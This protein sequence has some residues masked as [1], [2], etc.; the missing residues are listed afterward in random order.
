MLSPDAP[1][2][3]ELDLPF[4]L[5]TATRVRPSLH[6]IERDGTTTKVEPRLMRVLCVLAAAPGA[7]VSREALL[8]TVWPDASVQDEALTQ[9][10]SRLR[11]ALGDRARD[12]RVIETIPKAGY[13]LVAPVTAGDG[14]PT[15]PTEPDAALPASAPRRALWGGVVLAGLAVAAWIGR[16]APPLPTPQPVPLTTFRGLELDPAIAPDGQRFAFTWDQGD[17]ATSGLFI[18]QVGSEAPV[19]LTAPEARDRQPAWSLDGRTI[20]FARHRDGERQL[21]VVPSIGGRATPVLRCATDRN[22]PLAWTPDGG[23]LVLSD[24]A[25]AGGA[26]RLVRVSLDTGEVTPIT[27]PPAGSIGDAQPAFSP[28]GRRLAF[29]RS[30]LEGIADLFVLDLPDGTPRRVTTWEREVLGLAWSP[31]GR[32]LLAT[33]LLDGG[34]RLWRIPLDGDEPRP[35]YVNAERMYD[36][37][38]S[39]ST[40]QIVYTASDVEVN[41]RRVEVASGAHQSVVASTAWDSNPRFSPDGTRLAFASTRE[42]A[43]QIWVGGADGSRLRRLTSYQGAYVGPPSWSPDGRRLVFDARA[44]GQADLHVVP[45][46]GGPVER[47]TDTA[48]DE[49]NAFWSRD[50]ERVYYASNRDGDWQIFALHLRDG[51]IRQVT[52]QGGY[53]AM[54]SPDGV[55]LY[56]TR[57]DADGLWQ[58]RL[59]SGPEARLLPFPTA[60]NWGAWDV[61]ADGLSAIREADGSDWVLLD[62]ATGRERRRVSI[63]GRVPGQQRVLSTAPDGSAF[64]YSHVERFESDVKRVVWG[65]SL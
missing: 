48:Y 63:P 50:G 45:V 9:A 28:D 2:V 13:R 40:G 8:Q 62:H 65:S 29:V 4:R 10:V 11:R 64:V 20:A 41:I 3:A 56:I 24:A 34:H 14:T 18:K 33:T 55:T 44:E 39:A 43:P 38:V 17:R 36:L 53:A 47:L 59:P 1:P 49:V 46:A 35:I 57:N 58:K 22:T 32:S 16:P 25:R 52:T 23:S 19:Q 21:F 54:E 61:T 51:Q 15:P 27:S 42:V 5:G 7:V 26:S 6:Q 60:A 30:T 37:D 12:A 31:D